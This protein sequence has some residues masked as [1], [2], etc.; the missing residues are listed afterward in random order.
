MDGNMA[1]LKYEAGPLTNKLALVKYPQLKTH[2]VESN[3]NI[4]SMHI[5]ILNSLVKKGVML[6]Y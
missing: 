2:K 4:L 1:G 6:P 5:T 3:N